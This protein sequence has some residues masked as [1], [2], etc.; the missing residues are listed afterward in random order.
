VASC[1]N[2]TSAAT[3]NGSPVSLA[4]CNPANSGQQ[5]VP[6]ADQTLYNPHSGRCLYNPGS[7]T[8]GTQLV[9]QDCGASRLETWQLPYDYPTA[10]G[11]VQ[12]EYGPACAVIFTGCAP[13]P[14]IVLSSCVDDW[15]SG[16]ADGNVIDIHSCNGTAAQNITVTADGALQVLGKCLTTQGDGIA[17]GT[18]TVLWTCNGNSSEHWIARS[19]G[20]LINVRS[21]M[22]TCLDDPG[23]NTANGT[24]LQL[25]ACASSSDQQWALP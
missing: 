15:Q 12:A 4:S 6:R 24:Q 2:V 10:T 23:G 8:P 20:S 3:A 1:L 21:G 16:T 14:E 5:W 18:L 9:I 25:A 11:P 22:Q 17:A 7:A 19:D 13:Q